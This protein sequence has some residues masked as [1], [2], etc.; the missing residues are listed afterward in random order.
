MSIQATKTLIARQ[1]SQ[2][3]AIPE[4]PIT[5]L[6]TEL[7]EKCLF[8]ADIQGKENTRLVSRIWNTL[9]LT[10]SKNPEQ[11]DLNEFIRLLMKNLHTS[12]P[13]KAG[14][15][16]AIKKM[17]EIRARSLFTPAPIQRLF[18]FTKGCIIGVLKTLSSTRKALLQKA[19][20]PEI[21]TSLNSLFD[22]AE[23]SLEK[24]I[25]TRDFA[26]FYMVFTG[27]SGLS[28][29]YRG[30]LVIDAANA[31]QFLML[32]VLLNSGK[33]SIATRELALGYVVADDN[34]KCVQILL[35]RSSISVKGRGT[36]LDIATSQDRPASVRLLLAHGPITSV[37]LDWAI[38][39]A[40]DRGNLELARFIRSSAQITS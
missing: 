8:W 20:G 28:E 11:P 21:S 18:V 3:D 6:P 24:A 25:L 29:R 22:L 39:N 15:F 26:T 12:H 16:S 17:L 14:Q 13:N 37:A 7:V 19:I 33:I 30:G 2:T 40:M 27:H 23:M 4:G 10:A 31:G 38:E 34:E 35:D 1:S 36:L 9:T 32:Q 5:K